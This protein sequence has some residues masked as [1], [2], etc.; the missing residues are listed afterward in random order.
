[1]GVCTGRNRIRGMATR[2]AVSEA[3]ILASLN[4]VTEINGVLFGS[5]IG[6]DGASVLD[7]TESDEGHLFISVIDKNG[8][9]C[10]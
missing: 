7:V 6:Y 9:V 4:Y 2:Y 8:G 3:R 10:M 5:I 1:M